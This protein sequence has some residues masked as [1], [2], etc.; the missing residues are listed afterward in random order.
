MTEKSPA[1][2]QQDGALIIG[3]RCTDDDCDWLLGTD[4]PDHW[5]IIER[6]RLEHEDETGHQVTVET[7]RQQTILAEK[8]SMMD[9]TLDIASEQDIEIDWIC[10]ECEQSAEDLGATKRCPECDEPFREVLP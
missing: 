2:M 7:V 4:D 9:A 3:A 5:D 1:A 8:M 6:L 10:P